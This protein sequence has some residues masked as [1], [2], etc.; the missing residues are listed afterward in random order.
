VK[1]GRYILILLLIWGFAALYLN[2]T[3]CDELFPESDQQTP[4]VNT[5]YQSP[6]FG[7]IIKFATYEGLSYRDHID[8]FL[9][10]M[11]GY[12]HDEIIVSIRQDDPGAGDVPKGVLWYGSHDSKYFDCSHEEYSGN[13]QC[14]DPLP[15]DELLEKAE[16]KGIN[17]WV[18]FPVFYDDY[19]AINNCDPGLWLPP[20]LE[21]SIKDYVSDLLDDFLSHYSSRISGVVIDHIRTSLPLAVLSQPDKVAE[22]AGAL[23]DIAHGYGLPIGAF[24]KAPHTAEYFGQDYAMLIS[25]ERGRLDFLSPMVYWDDEGVSPTEAAGWVEQMASE[26][27]KERVVPCIPGRGSECAGASYSEQREFFSGIE[28]LVHGYAMYVHRYENGSN[29]G[30]EAPGC[31]YDRQDVYISNIN[32]IYGHECIVPSPTPAPTPGGTCDHLCEFGET[33]CQSGQVESCTTDADGCR[34]WGPGSSCGSSGYEGDNYCDGGDVYKDY[35]DR[36][37]A[38]GACYASTTPELIAACGAG[39]CSNG[40]CVGCSPQAYTSC[41]DDD[42]YYYD[43]C[44]FLGNK[45]QECG[46]SGWTGAPYCKSSDLYQMYTER[47]CSSDSCYEST[48]EQLKEDCGSSG[49]DDGT[50]PALDQQQTNYGDP[51]SFYYDGYKWA[52]QSF[53]P[54]GS[55][56]SKVVLK[57]I[58][59]YY[60]YAHPCMWPNDEDETIDVYIT[61]DSGS[62]VARTLDYPLCGM[63]TEFG[64]NS[65]MRE[66]IPFTTVYDP[67]VSGDTYWIKIMYNG[68]HLSTEAPPLRWDR[69]TFNAYPD[70]QSQASGDSSTDDFWFQ[71]Y[72]SSGVPQCE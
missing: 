63:P 11:D 16:N 55:E 66:E 10:W 43:S 68:V 54:V 33:R 3:G 14:A 41:Y 5:S 71:V 6:Q 24:V 57:L 19:H 38:G 52:K 2:L 17:V 39:G 61:D 72:S 32:E 45:A 27:G 26:L 8:R 64:S 48:Y 53:V 30:S 70:G 44:D 36:G 29:A 50:S 1:A 15:F 56:V 62:T 9:N 37:C 23:A 59:E 58:V 34:I 47:G 4:S 7:W 18:W 42:V 22:F 25:P 67:F 46:N 31:Y 51:Y 65:G 28:D 49:C 20:E 40:T 69:A 21:C 12:C 35:V 60:S 13:V